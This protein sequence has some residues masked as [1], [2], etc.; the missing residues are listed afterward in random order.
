MLAEV[1]FKIRKGKSPM[2]LDQF[3]NFKMGKSPVK[4]YQF[5]DSMDAC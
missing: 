2:K 5:K 4:I 3:L 1:L